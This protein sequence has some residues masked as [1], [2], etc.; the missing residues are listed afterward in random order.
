MTPSLGRI[1]ATE[2]CFPKFIS[3]RKLQQLHC[4]RCS[5]ANSKARNVVLEIAALARVIQT[6]PS[7]SG[8][9]DLPNALLLTL[10]KLV[11]ERK[12]PSR[13]ALWGW[14][15]CW[16][17]HSSTPGHGFGVPL[18]MPGLLTTAPTSK[19][20]FPHNGCQFRELK[21]CLHPFL[22]MK[23][24]QAWLFKASR[25]PW[26]PTPDPSRLPQDLISRFSAEQKGCIQIKH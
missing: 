12:S 13:N 21:K 6:I 26:A 18:W 19:C 8:N 3:P 11:L 25:D 17:C 24:F 7:T 5:G 23:L 22:W 20:S 9:T 4:L 14:G 2:L 15:L 1:A 16:E 10:I